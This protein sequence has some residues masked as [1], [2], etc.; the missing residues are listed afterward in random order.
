MRISPK[1]TFLYAI[2]IQSRWS[3]RILISST[4]AVTLLVRDPPE[5]PSIF[6]TSLAFQTLKSKQ[7]LNKCRSGDA[8][9]ALGPPWIILV[10]VTLTGDIFDPLTYLLTCL[11]TYL[12]TH[13]VTYLLT[14]LKNFTLALLGR[15]AHSHVTWTHLTYLKQVLKECKRRVWR[16]SQQYRCCAHVSRELGI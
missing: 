14:Y 13:L 2:C 9:A 16:S 12:L 10:L 4:R 3:V 8:F 7:M 1:V 6:S 11:L 15:A 5:Q